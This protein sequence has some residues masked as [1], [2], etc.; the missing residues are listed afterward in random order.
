MTEDFRPYMLPGSAI[1]NERSTLRCCLSQKK[2]THALNSTDKKTGLPQQ[3]TLQALLTTATA[4]YL[5]NFKADSRAPYHLRHTFDRDM[6]LFPP[7]LP[8]RLY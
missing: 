5:K 8:N 6:E 7:V 4:A 2:F 3:E 1:S